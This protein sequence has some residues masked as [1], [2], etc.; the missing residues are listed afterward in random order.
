[1]G[2]ISQPASQPA[3]VLSAS[4][5][6]I[7]QSAA[8]RAG[9]VDALK[10]E[11]TE[12][13][14]GDWCLVQH[15]RITRQGRNS[16]GGLGRRG[17]SFARDGVIRCASVNGDVLRALILAAFRIRSFRFQWPADLLTSWAFEMET[18]IL[19]WYVMV[20]TG[21]V[22]LLTVFGSLQFL[23]TLAAPMLGVLGDQLGGRV[24]L[25]AIRMT[26][27]TLA[28]LMTLLA[29]TGMLTPA[30]V[31]VA[32]ALGG[33]VR[34]NDLVMR[35]A[36]IGETIP[37]AHRLGALGLSRA[38]SDSARVAGALAGAALSTLLGIGPAYIVVT[39]LYAGSLA[40]TLGV[41]RRPAAPAVFDGRAGVD[42]PAALRTG[43]T[44][45]TAW[46]IS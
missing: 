18:L 45:A 13:Y 28:S 20:N 14:Q 36:L 11:L 24:M 33:L 30:W 8:W 29:L 19:G 12:S 2:T 22:L 4:I 6:A 43:V 26:Y 17:A 7:T 3:P 16:G 41:A 40:L 38:T 34:P 27:I 25:C 15:G 23:G 44:S 10:R 35:N 1:M 21:S 9:S 42:L 32:A 37:P 39:S 31:F 46:P 5:A